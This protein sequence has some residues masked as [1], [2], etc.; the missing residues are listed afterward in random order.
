MARVQKIIQADDD[1]VSCSKN[2]AFTIAIATEMFIYYLSEQARH[3]SLAENRK[4]MKRSIGY[5]D[6]ATAVASRDNL[7]F[8]A[9]VVPRTITYRQHLAKQA[10][11]AKSETS[12][13]TAAGGAVT[14]GQKTLEQM[15]KRDP[16]DIEMDDA[17]VIDGPRLNGH[18][19]DDN[20]DDEDEDGMGAKGNQASGT[21]SRHGPGARARHYFNQQPNGYDA[22]TAESHLPMGA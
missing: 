17:D 7:E 22:E 5:K 14:Y 8:L 21:T 3:V 10:K 4:Y 6:V 2:A 15:A 1:T 12:A 20:D 19:L 18:T 9:D 13:N 16:G 11:K